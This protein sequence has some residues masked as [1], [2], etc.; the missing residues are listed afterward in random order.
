[1]MYDIEIND[2]MIIL[3]IFYLQLCNPSYGNVSMCM[4]WLSG[5]LNNQSFIS[6]LIPWNVLF[7]KNI[8]S[9]HRP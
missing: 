2:S 1:M 3:I 9:S 7:V 5:A 6:T 4:Q 8:V